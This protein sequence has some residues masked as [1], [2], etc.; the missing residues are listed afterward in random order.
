MCIC[1]ARLFT[2]LPPPVVDGPLVRGQRGA[3]KREEGVNI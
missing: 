2:R 3:K 1:L